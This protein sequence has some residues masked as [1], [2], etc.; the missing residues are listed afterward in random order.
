MGV[1]VNAVAPGPIATAMTAN[2]P[3]SLKQALPV[4]RLGTPGDVREAIL[5]L[6]VER[7][8]LHYR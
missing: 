3:E 6:P 7:C 2:L 1:T 4:G 8:W 5:S